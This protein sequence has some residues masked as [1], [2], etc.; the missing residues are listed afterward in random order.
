MNIAVRGMLD[1]MFRGLT[2]VSIVFLFGFLIFTIANRKNIA[3]FYLKDAYGLMKASLI[4]RTDYKVIRSAAQTIRELAY[5]TFERL[6]FKP[7]ELEIFIGCENAYNAHQAESY[8]VVE[9]KWLMLL[10]NA[11]TDKEREDALG[12]IQLSILHELCHYYYKDVFMI[13]EIFNRF[14]KNCYVSMLQEIRADLFAKEHFSGTVE[15]ANRLFELKTQL[16]PKNKFTK[17]AFI[18]TH[19]TNQIRLEL[20][21]TYS[22]VDAS[23]ISEIVEMLND[24]YNLVFKRKKTLQSN[25]DTFMETYA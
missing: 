20:F 7:G 22:C 2:F 4:Y 3:F 18:I 16:L 21:R 11:S 23:N 8:V 6:G 1:G 19:P 24:R 13:R 14:R 15:E 12:L 17:L 10:V 25:I 5:E 9:L